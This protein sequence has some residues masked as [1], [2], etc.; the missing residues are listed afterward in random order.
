MTVRHQGSRDVDALS[1][2]IGPDGVGTHNLATT[3]L[4]HLERVV[5]AW[6][7]RDRDDHGHPERVDVIAATRLLTAITAR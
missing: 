6:V 5:E 2:R 4:L 1:P 7:R 3:Q